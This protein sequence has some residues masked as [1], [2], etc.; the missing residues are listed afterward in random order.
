MG[1]EKG[2]EGA[3]LGKLEDQY[4][5]RDELFSQCIT[6]KGNP[7]LISK[8]SDDVLVLQTLQHLELVP[9]VHLLPPA[10]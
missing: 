1:G 4:V 3:L 5:L 2:K 8:C 10:R 7:L 9:Q 6:L